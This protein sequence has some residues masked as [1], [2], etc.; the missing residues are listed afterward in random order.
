MG[1]EQLPGDGGSG[2]ASGLA[3]RCIRAGLE[4]AHSLCLAWALGTS[5]VGQDLANLPDYVSK[6]A[7]L[8]AVFLVLMIDELLTKYL[9]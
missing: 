6:L 9:P 7:V 1:L 8:S 4:I 2:G 3:P 5:S